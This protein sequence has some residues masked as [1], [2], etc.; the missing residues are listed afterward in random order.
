MKIIHKD[1]FKNFSLPLSIFYSIHIADAIAKD[2]EEFDIFI[3]L[4]KKYVEQLKQFSLDKRDVELQ[5]NTG[6]KERFGKGSY[7]DLY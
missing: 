5:N 2:G 3:G 6:D 7:E 1:N 4:E